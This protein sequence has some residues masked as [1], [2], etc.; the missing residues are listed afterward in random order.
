MSG[1]CTPS[2]VKREGNTNE[3][4]YPNI[5]HTGV[6]STFL[7]VSITGWKVRSETAGQG[8]EG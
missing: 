8:A 5:V 2:V 3:Y 4:K 1:G 7:W 6:E